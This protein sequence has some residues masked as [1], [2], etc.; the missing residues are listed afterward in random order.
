MS[1]I[2]ATCGLDMCD[3]FYTGTPDLC[4]KPV[5]EEIARSGG[6]PAPPV[7]CGHAIRTGSGRFGGGSAACRRPAGHGGGHSGVRVYR[8]AIRPGSETHAVLELLDEVEA[9]TRRAKMAEEQRGEALKV[10]KAERE[11]RE[12]FER[13]MRALLSELVTP[14]RDGDH[15]TSMMDRV[16][17]IIRGEKPQDRIAELENE[18]AWLKSEIEKLEAGRASWATRNYDAGET[19]TLIA[20]REWLEGRFDR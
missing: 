19:D 2:C 18:V 6:I 15:I 4:P 11:A 5:A 10:A 9:Q 12:S 20:L 8:G 16:A 17:E 14:P 7:E 13:G 3:H 1:E